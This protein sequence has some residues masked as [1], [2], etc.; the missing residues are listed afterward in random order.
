MAIPKLQPPEEDK[1]DWL[2]TYADA[3]TLL[4]AFFV[5]LLNFSKIDIPAFEEAAAGIANEIG[6]GP[7]EVSP[8]SLM[9]LDLQDMVYNMQADEVVEVEK[10]DKGVVIEL[11]SSAFYKPGSAEIRDEAIPVLD[12]IAEMLTQPRYRTYMIE[13]E[14]HT[15]DDPIHTALYPSNWELSAGRATRVV[16]HF[17]ERGMDYTRLKA[18]GFAE[19]RP[20]VPNRD[21]QGAPIPENQSENRRVIVR[22]YPMSL[23]QR[24]QF[25]RRIEIVDLDNEIQLQDAPQQPQPENQ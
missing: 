14:G 15:D 13:I 23:D 2:T 4:M 17:I 22:V 7:K 3:I 19:T 1:E 18:S 6:M 9:V 8:I 20:K 11:A 25:Q 24:A 10:D 12:Q 21:E 16:R 5:M